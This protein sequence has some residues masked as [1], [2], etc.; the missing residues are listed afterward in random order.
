MSYSATARQESIPIDR[1]SEIPPPLYSGDAYSEC[2]SR[3][4]ARGHRATGRARARRPRFLCAPAGGAGARRSQCPVVVPGGLVVVPCPAVAVPCRVTLH[5]RFEH[6]RAAGPATAPARHAWRREAADDAH[7]APRVEIIGATP[8]IPPACPCLLHPRRKHP[9][10]RAA[11]R[12][13]PRR[14]SSPRRPLSEYGFSSRIWGLGARR[15]TGEILFD[16]S[17]PEDKKTYKKLS[18]KKFSELTS[19]LDMLVIP[20]APDNLEF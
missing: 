12:H 9:T 5:P 3:A 1:D 10:P 17:V 4:G 6:R 14:S 8:R 7:R 20:E 18:C 15:P 2:D 11:T 16:L 13:H 19:E